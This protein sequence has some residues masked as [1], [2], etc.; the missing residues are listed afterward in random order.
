LSEE[1]AAMLPE[2]PKEEARRVCHGCG[3]AKFLPY[4]IRSG[5]PK[6]AVVRV[7]CSVACA[8]LHSPGFTGKD[9][10]Q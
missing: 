10:R 7:Y 4:S 9:P 5:D 1:E 8:Q 3:Q 6:T 2:L